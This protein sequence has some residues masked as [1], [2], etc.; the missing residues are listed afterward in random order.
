[1]LL[2]H[3]CLH[4]TSP[5]L[6]SAQHEPEPATHIAREWSGLHG[7]STFSLIDSHDLFR[8]SD[9]DLITLVGYNVTVAL[10]VNIHTPFDR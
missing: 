9:T 6:A 4:R 8:R 2:I 1:M 5:P 10:D 7:T 3:V